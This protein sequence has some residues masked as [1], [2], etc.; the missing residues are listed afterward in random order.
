MRDLLRQMLLALS[1]LHH[2]NVTHRDVKPDNLLLS[3]VA[4]SAHPGRGGPPTCD[5]N[6]SVHQEGQEGAA[7]ED[8]NG[9]DDSAGAFCLH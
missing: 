7:D 6:S 1:A 4:P 9:S 2:A 8:A 5:S 3:V